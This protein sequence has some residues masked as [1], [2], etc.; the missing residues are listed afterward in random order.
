MLAAKLKREITAGYGLLELMQLLEEGNYN[1]MF[2][3][4][5]IGQIGTI[6]LKKYGFDELVITT[7]AI[8]K[9]LAIAVVKESNNS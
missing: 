5:E 9:D 6:V 4:T 8:G 2:W 3:N 7:P 1:V